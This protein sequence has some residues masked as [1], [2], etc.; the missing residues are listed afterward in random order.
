[1]GGGSSFAQIATGDY[2]IQNVESG[3][4]LNHGSSWGTHVTVDGAGCVITVGGTE[5]AYTLHHA[6]I[7]SNKYQTEDGWSD[8]VTPGKFA[9]EDAGD[10]AYY[11]KCSNN[12]KYY[13]WAGGEGQW[14]DE[15]VVDEKGE[16]GAFQWKFVP[17]DTR[18]AFTAGNDVTYKIKNPDFAAYAIDW[19]KAC[20]NQWAGDGV[21]NWAN[22]DQVGYG[23]TGQFAEKWVAAPAGLANIS[24]RQTITD[25]PAGKYSLSVTANAELQGTG[26]GSGAYVYAGTEQTELGMWS[27][28][29]VDFKSTGADVEIGVK[30]VSTT[31]NW[32]SFDKFRL[33][34]IE[35][36]V[37]VIAT[38]TESPVTAEADKWY[39]VQIPAKSTFTVTTTNGATI[40]YTQDA[41]AIGSE[42]SASAANDDE[43]EFE[44]GT[45]YIKASAASE[46]T[47]AAKSYVY[48]L[49]TATLTAADGKYVQNNTFSVTFPS[50]GS[51]DPEASVA[52]VAGAKAT[53]NGNEVA[54]TSTEHGFTFSLGELTAGTAYSIDIPAGVYGYAGKEMNE[55]IQLTVNTPCVFDGIYYVKSADGRYISRGNNYNTRA[56]ADN[57][58]VAVRTVT[59]ADNIT[60]FQFIDNNLY[61]F[62]ANNKTVYTDNATKPKNWLVIPTFGG[63]NIINMND[64]G[65]LYDYLTIA[66]TPDTGYKYC[67][68]VCSST[69]YTV[70]TFEATTDHPAQMAAK[71]DA[72]A[73]A[74]AAD[75]GQDGIT[76]KAGLDELAAILPASEVEVDAK[77]A[78]AELYQNQGDI[79]QTLTDIPNG[80]YKV[81]IKAFQR[82]TFNSNDI[83]A[84][85]Y[86]GPTTTLYANDQEVQLCSVYEQATPSANA[87]SGGSPADWQYDG[88]YYPNNIQSSKAA[89]EAGNYTNEIYVNVTDGTLKF[90]IF[91]GNKCGNG[92]WL[93]YK[94]FAVTYYGETTRTTAI[95]KYGTICLPYAFNA[96][97]ATLYSAS[98]NG[99]TVEL[100]TVD[101]PVA[102][103]PYIYQA[104]TDAQTFSYASGAIVA[105]PIAAEPL[106]GV[107]TATPAPVGS[108]VMQTLND[109]QKFYIVAEGKQPTVGANKA[110]LQVSSGAKAFSIG[111]GDD[112]ATAVDAV[113]ALINGN[114]EIYSIGGVKLQK[115]QKGINIVNGVPVMVK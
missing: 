52:L 4:Y 1:M 9:F 29:S 65:S 97:G 13:K 75:F 54:L 19:G 47:I 18:E 36:A 38:A 62:D 92:D 81:S 99:T 82:V 30:T 49:G 45:L 21:T 87:W 78:G 37:S 48:A 85:K 16:S 14:G 110:Y 61:L 55:N 25:L 112:N 40:N 90:G 41:N 71:K 31:A 69:S 5:G 12:G 114:A 73:A 20:T 35:P 80:L 70:F 93:Y 58:G 100:T 63:Y 32:I 27:T 108:Y 72:Q 113:N 111:F 68:I 103:V 89:M 105:E 98:I 8:N 83:V 17:K 106:V 7:A 91:K 67:N 101:T 59:N 51:T 44:Y 107:F 22:A 74:V 53:V 104:T 102:G 10:G 96:E 46:V 3:M 23:Y 60:T 34:C 79:T 6:G 11:I 86:Y 66:S 24:H 95:D 42:V 88:N 76:T 26:A 64:N 15:C 56:I 50:E 39:A 109:E 77:A 28:K 84:G 115:L 43:V 94:D 57:Y 33:T 2:Y